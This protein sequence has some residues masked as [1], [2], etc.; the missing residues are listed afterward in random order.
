MISYPMLDVTRVECSS[1]LLEDQTETE[2][3]S[4]KTGLL[5]YKL[6]VYIMI[7]LIFGGKKT[8][9]LLCK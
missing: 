1:C 6:D 5:I 8:K 2:T 9:I 7:R 4:V 3:Q